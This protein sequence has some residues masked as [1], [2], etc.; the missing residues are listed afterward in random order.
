[1][2]LRKVAYVGRDNTF[3]LEFSSVDVDG[4]ETLV[5]FS[6]IYSVLVELVNGPAETEVTTLTAGNIADTSPGS[7]IIRLALGKIPGL[8][9]GTYML[10]LAYKTTVGD[11]EP[12]QL[13]HERGA[14]PV[15]V[16]VFDASTDTWAADTV[17]IDGG[18]V[19]D[20]DDE[21]LFR[22]HRYLAWQRTG[23]FNP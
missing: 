6:G 2:A 5:S 13:V 1:M 19:A 7:G 4:A 15:V 22:R 11:T 16:Q 20:G 21:F 18:E 14:S 3:D 8:T 12:T 10:R 9:A 17:Q 23:R